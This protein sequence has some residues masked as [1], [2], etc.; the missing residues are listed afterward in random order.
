MLYKK[1]LLV[2]ILS[3][4]NSNIYSIQFLIAQFFWCLVLLVLI[5]KIA[6]AQDS[7][8]NIIKVI[9]RGKRK[10]DGLF[11]KSVLKSDL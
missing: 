11:S 5:L 10:N 4:K 7:K 1:H 8:R 2:F 6:E 9:F 3:I